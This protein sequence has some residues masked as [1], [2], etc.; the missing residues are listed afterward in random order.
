M[1]KNKAKKNTSLKKKKIKQAN[2]S[3]TSKPGLISQTR[4][5]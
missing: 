4:N 1:L 3:K 2:P 5:K